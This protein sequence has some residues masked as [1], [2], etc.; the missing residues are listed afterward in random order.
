MVVN[1]LGEVI[2][3]KAHEED[4]FTVALQKELLEETRT[5][6]PFWKDADNFTIINE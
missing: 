2:Y 5:R 6:F 3:S 4:I 1:P